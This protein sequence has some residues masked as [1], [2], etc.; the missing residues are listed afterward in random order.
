MLMDNRLKQVPV[1]I[2]ANKQDMP[3]AMSASEVAEKM[4][5]VQLQGRTW[6]IKAC[7]ASK[8]PN[9]QVSE[10]TLTI[11]NYKVQLWDINGEL[12]NRQIWPNYYQKAKVLIFVLDSKDALRL[13]EAR[14]VLCDVLMHQEL[15]KAPLLIVSNK[16]DTSGSLPV[17]TV[18]DL[19]G[20]E[21]LQ[22][23]DW[24]IKECSMQTGAGIPEIMDW[25][26]NKIDKNKK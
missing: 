9:K 18:I 19:M 4:S 25:I 23:R 5:L 22:G 16:K 17:S 14:C 21:R 11:N 2:F 1:L 13:S 24:S 3:D 12:K 20:L 26:T 10:W 8:E 15:N 7:T 6:E